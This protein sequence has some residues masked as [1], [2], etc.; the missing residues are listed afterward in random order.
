MIGSVEQFVEA[1]EGAAVGLV[2]HLLAALVDHHIPL[3]VEGLLSDRRQ[4]EAHA[5]RLQPQ[6]EIEVG[7]GQDLVVI[8]AVVPGRSVGHSASLL[9][10]VEVI[11]GA[12]MLTALEEHVL[13]EMGES[14]APRTL[15]L[16]A[17]V[18]PE[19]DRHQRQSIIGM[20]HHPQTVVQGVTLDMEAVFGA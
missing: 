12:H 1:F 15:V 3:I 11:V 5:V 9:H 13:E 17:D 7:R 10:M 14:G 2:V 6:A 16:R 8:G 18:V 19:I 20:Q 4:Q